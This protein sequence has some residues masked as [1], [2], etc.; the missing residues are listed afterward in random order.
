MLRISS[1]VLICFLVSFEAT[2]LAQKVK[3]LKVDDYDCFCKREYTVLKK[4]S[5]VKHGRYRVT[6]VE[7]Y[8]ISDGYYK[9]N[10]KDSLWTYFNRYKATTSSQGYYYNDVKVGVWKYFNHVIL[11]SGILF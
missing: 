10:K 4:Q 5:D 2:T 3:K 1:V 11:Y 9:M 7:G 8:P 6:H